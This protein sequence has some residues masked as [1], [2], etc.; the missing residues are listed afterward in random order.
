MRWTERGRGVLW[1]KR[2]LLG[3]SDRGLQGMRA[4]KG[5]WAE[6]PA[7]AKAEGCVEALCICR[8]MNSAV[9]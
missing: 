7:Y 4:E 6:G 8:V 3:F 5:T 2:H 9:L 1:R